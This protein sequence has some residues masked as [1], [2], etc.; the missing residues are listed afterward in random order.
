MRPLQAIVKRLFLPIACFACIAWVAV[1]VVIY[2]KLP[3]HNIGITVLL[4]VAGIV[5]AFP[6]MGLVMG[7]LRRMQ[8]DDDSSESHDS[9]L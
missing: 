5:L 8:A 6:W 1:F 7:M 4:L 2:T 3:Q 9:K